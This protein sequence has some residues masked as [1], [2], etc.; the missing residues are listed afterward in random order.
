ME[1]TADFVNRLILDVRE[2]S[3]RM[4]EALAILDTLRKK[5]A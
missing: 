1:K 2:L 5:E 4:N 3:A